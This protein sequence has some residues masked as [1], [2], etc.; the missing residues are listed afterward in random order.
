MTELRQ[1]RHFLI[2]SPWRTDLNRIDLDMT[3]LAASVER[4][5][6]VVD[7]EQSTGVKSVAVC[8]WFVIIN[9]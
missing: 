8:Q 9:P 1:T 6:D 3:S 4:I 5:L 7:D 2:Q